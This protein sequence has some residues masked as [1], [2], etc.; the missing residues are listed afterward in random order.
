MKLKGSGNQKGADARELMPELGNRKQGAV[1]GLSHP[2][3]PPARRRE[4]LAW[5]SAD[6]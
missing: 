4:W 1:G 6:P 3:H 5:L 2:V